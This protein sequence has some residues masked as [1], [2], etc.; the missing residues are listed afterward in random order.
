MP[1]DMIQQIEKENERN[2]SNEK[3]QKV[4]DACHFIDNMVKDREE[5]AKAKRR[6]FKDPDIFKDRDEE[7]DKILGEAALP[8][9]LERHRIRKLKE[10]NE[11]ISSKQNEII[12]I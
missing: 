12:K 11:Q 6:M 5:Q 9:S 3:K 7:M 10:F 1:P 2:L 4:W 8:S